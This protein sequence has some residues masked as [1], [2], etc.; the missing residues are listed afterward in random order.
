MGTTLLQALRESPYICFGG[1]GTRSVFYYGMFETLAKRPEYDEFRHQ[2]RGCAGSSSGAM[3]ALAVAVGAD[4]NEL[5]SILSDFGAQHKT[6]IPSLSVQTL[7]DAYGL[8]E[9]EVL[10]GLI[11]RF[12]EALGLARNTTFQS[13]T[14]LAKKDLRICATNLHTRSPFYFSVETSPTLTLRDALFMSMTLPF[15][16]RPQRYM[17]ELYV[18]GGM[19]C[20]VP[21]GAFPGKS[22]LAITMTI[23]PTTDLL[24]IRDVAVSVVSC[25]LAV[26]DVLLDQYAETHPARVF[27]FD[28][29]S[30][31]DVNITAC[32][33]YFADQRKR[34]AIAA[35]LQEE[36]RMTHALAALLRIAVHEHA[37]FKESPTS[38]RVQG[39]SPPM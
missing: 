15:I 21:I 4:F 10:Q 36:K 6:A 7:F 35:L 22:P 32:P 5:C 26:Q 29:G 17:G 27:R 12:I 34:G 18:D 33:A 25:T 28:D 19:T 39:E 1:C 20:N 14:R 37:R 16:F 9:G 2:L 23:P 30:S 3:M 24:S 38:H 11:D 8:D 13:L 31:S